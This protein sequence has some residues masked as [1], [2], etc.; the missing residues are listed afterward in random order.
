M[1]F[2]KKEGTRLAVDRDKP[3]HNLTAFVKTA[4]RDGGE[5]GLL[6]VRT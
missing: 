3:W 2:C 5:K 1:L 4:I 6:E